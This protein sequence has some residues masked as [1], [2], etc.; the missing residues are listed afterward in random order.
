[1]VGVTNNMSHINMS[2]STYVPWLIHMCDMTHEYVYLQIPCWMRWHVYSHPYVFFNMYIY[3][4]RHVNLSI[5]SLSLSLCVPWR[6]HTWRDQ[7]TG[8][9]QSVVSH[10]TYMCLH[11]SIYLFQY[12]CHDVFTC[13]T[14]LTHTCFYRLLAVCSAY[15]RPR[16]SLL[17]CAMTHSHARHDSC[18]CVSTTSLVCSVIAN[19]ILSLW[20]HVFCTYSFSEFRLRNTG[21]RRVIGCLIFMGHFLQKSPIIRGAFAKSDLQLKAS[22]E[23][24]PPCVHEM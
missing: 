3:V 2:L 24:L 21:R 15:K 20:I 11:M 18:T 10:V 6:V 5:V 9:F 1:M 13:M 14:W 19:V 23:S 16:I 22:Y 8:I 7:R 17:M 12:V 4:V